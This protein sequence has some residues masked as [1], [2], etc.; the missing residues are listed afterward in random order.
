MRV[1]RMPVMKPVRKVLSQVMGRRREVFLRGSSERQCLH[2][3]AP[4]M[5]LSLQKG[6]RINGLV[7][8]T[9]P[10]WV[11]RRRRRGN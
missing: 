8:S 6:Q 9:M 4:S 3:M 2:L 11:G 7:A 5:M 10:V 1:K